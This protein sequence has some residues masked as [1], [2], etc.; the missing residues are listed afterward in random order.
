MEIL[1]AFFQ[2]GALDIRV[3][4]D[5][6]GVKGDYTCPLRSMNLLDLVVLV[7]AVMI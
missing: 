3:F 4:D 7:I 5:R 2:P 6:L 1:F